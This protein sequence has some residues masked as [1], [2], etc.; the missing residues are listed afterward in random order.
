[1]NSPVPPPPQD[2]EALL[3]QR[4]ALIFLISITIG[5]ALGYLTHAQL[6]STTA[7]FITAILTFGGSLPIANKLIR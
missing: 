6:H 4:S 2:D 5:G 1:M 7:A 3:S